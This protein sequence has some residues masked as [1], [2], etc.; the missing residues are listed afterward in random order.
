MSRKA[1]FYGY[2]INTENFALQ[3]WLTVLVTAF[4]NLREKSL[5]FL[6]LLTLRKEVHQ[7]VS[8]QRVY[9]A[10]ECLCIRPCDR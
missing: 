4:L 3:T 8:I 7:Q 6:F 2:G 5:T 10:E 1:V 9:I